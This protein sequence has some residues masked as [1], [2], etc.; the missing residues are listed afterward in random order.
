[1]RV[2]SW[3]G[4]MRFLTVLRLFINIFWAFYSLK[5]KRL[6]HS[7]SWVASK[8]EELYTSEARR[9]RITAVKLGGLLIKLGQFFST[10]VD[11]LPQA[12]TR[13]L[14]Q[15]QDE[16]EPVAFDEIRKVVEAE[17]GRSLSEVYCHVEESPLASASLGQ[18]H[19][20]QLFGGQSVAIKVQRPGIEDLV[21]IDLKAIRRAID[22]LK[23]FTDWERVIDLDAIYREFADTVWAELDYINEGR[24]AETIARNS[25]GDPDIIIP[26]IFWDYTT[27]R[28]LTM[29]FE[30][31]IK[32]TDYESLE[33]AGV[34]RKD[35]ARKLLQTYVKQVLVDGFFHADPH[36]GN[37][38]VDPTG[39]LVLLD[40]GMV[41]TISERL[42]GTLVEMALAMVKRDNIQVVAYLKQIGF[43]RRDADSEAVARAIAVLMEE[44]LG[45]GQELLSPDLAAL[46]EDI[47]HLVY[48][49]PFQIPANFTFLGRA[50]GILY[51]IC[52][53]L[54]PDID[55]L[56]E[57]KPFLAE[58]TGDKNE[59]WGLVKSKVTT[60][61]GSLV[62]IPPLA[63]RVL[64][65]VDRGDL[66]MKVPLQPLEQAIKENTRAVNSLA[67]AVVF[68]FSL[69][70]A[71]YLLVNHR[72][73]EARFG[74]LCSGIAF[75]IMLTRNRTPRHRRPPH[76]HVIVRRE[77]E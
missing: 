68:G 31:G 30:R 55:F 39:K 59:L 17:F 69:L 63:E 45:S 11:L 26:G 46:L 71:T 36:P 34:D 1:M 27:R 72:V 70:A 77:R 37:L 73:I 8:R 65:R 44:F 13:E 23:S 49:Q 54:D 10:R 29:E 76:P 35:I 38:F 6:W 33:K 7:E 15:L 21:H 48:E 75:I 56:E 2:N 66:V 18:V 57:A 61:G 28:V 58:V 50:L 4:L 42:R 12:S 40:F 24:N 67:W 53:G 25:T 16:V 14:A 43:L 41:G 5:F 20:G 9:F 60:L 62:E 19:L 74:F 64:R 32:I 51:G 52:I 47:E 3:S 22:I